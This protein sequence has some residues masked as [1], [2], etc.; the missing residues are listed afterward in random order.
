M[1]E[2][3]HSA[4]ND[5]HETQW[6]LVLFF[7]LSAACSMLENLHNRYKIGNLNGPPVDCACARR[8]DDAKDAAQ[9]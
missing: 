2:R 6:T 3:G 1:L 4:I 8:T 9:R 7:D 5:T